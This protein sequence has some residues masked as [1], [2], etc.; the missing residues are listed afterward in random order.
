MSGRGG[1]PGGK[2]PLSVAREMF[3]KLI[4]WSHLPTAETNVM[5]A[6]VFERYLGLEVGDET[7]T[8]LAATPQTRDG[9]SAGRDS[10]DAREGEN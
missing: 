8:T 9:P 4:E 7:A 2:V 5:L 1:M 6:E 3:F 10:G